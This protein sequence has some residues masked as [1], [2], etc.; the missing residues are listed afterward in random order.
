MKQRV[1]SAIVA[2][3]IVIAAI[4]FGGIFLYLM[5]GLAACIDIFELNRAFGYKDKKMILAMTMIAAIV[6]IVCFFG[7]QK[8]IA[9]TVVGFL[10]MTE[11]AA[12]VLVYP[13]V[14]LK[15]V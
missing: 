15:Q 8:D 12:Y 4:Y 11:F 6:Y 9:K 5:A 2:L 14:E 3:P 13:K 7:E 1:L 10:L